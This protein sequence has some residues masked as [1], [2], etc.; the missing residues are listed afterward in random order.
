M[1]GS[2]SASP[3]DYLF[4]ECF[5]TI[6]SM[7][8][9]RLGSP[10][11]NWV[12]NSGGH[13][14][15]P[16]YFTI[17]SM[18]GSVIERGLNYG[19]STMG[20]SIVVYGIIRRLMGL[21]YDLPLFCNAPSVDVLLPHIKRALQQIQRWTL[22][23]FFMF[24]EQWMRQTLSEHYMSFE[25][26][27]T[28]LNQLCLTAVAKVPSEAISLERAVW[29]SCYANWLDIMVPNM[30]DRAKILIND[31]LNYF[32]MP[33]PPPLPRELCL[34]LQQKSQL[35]LYECD[36]A[37]EIVF[38]LVVVET[39]LALGHRVVM[40]AKIG[41]VLNDVTVTDVVKIIQTS[42]RFD[43]LNNALESSQLRII[44]QNNSPMV[45]KYLPMASQAYQLYSA[46]CDLYWL[47]GQ[48]NFQTMPIFNYGVFPKRIHYRAPILVSFI[49]KAPLVR[50]CLNQLLPKDPKLGDPLVM[51]V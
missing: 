18:G 51:L 20:I 49:V 19:C 25:S 38:D 26:I 5:N 44:H 41:P 33:H 16:D 32:D 6:Q 46:R 27:K 30:V 23:E 3:T 12:I 4:E 36:N 8:D 42:Q 47:K 43:G 22:V 39:L 24:M 28:N 29:A 50:V 48:A 37:G 10:G 21:F 9:V 31:A 11:Y 7:V 35:I 17:Q 2:A 1:P 34:L 15:R 45:G 13:L 40:V 14:F